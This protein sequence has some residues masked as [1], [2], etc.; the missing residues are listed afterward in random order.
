MVKA[1][2]H[3]IF[4]FGGFSFCH[5]QITVQDCLKRCDFQ[6]QQFIE[7]DFNAG[8]TI[9]GAENKYMAIYIYPGS[10][11]QVLCEAKIYANSDKTTTLV[12]TGIYSDE[13][14][15]WYSTFYYELSKKLKTFKPREEGD[16]VPGISIFSLMKDSKAITVLGSY[17]PQIKKEYLGEQAD[18]EDV[19]NEVYTP[20]FDIDEHK[21]VLIVSLEVC[22]YIPNNEVDIS[23]E[24]WK[25]IQTDFEKIT[26]QYNSKEKIFEVSD[27]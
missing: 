1:F 2:I 15:T 17:L 9:T 8:D 6:L 11:M 21:N 23:E 14:C 3:F 27:L 10:D 16:V 12:I 7:G 22:D 18:L 20:H 4:I 5:S 13:Q 25:V 19:V 26:L 24:D